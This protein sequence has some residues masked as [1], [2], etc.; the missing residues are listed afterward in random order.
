MS[1]LLCEFTHPCI[2]YGPIGY[3]RLATLLFD[4]PIHIVLND[5]IDQIEQ[6]DE[7][8][9]LFPPKDLLKQGVTI[10]K[11][12]QR[13]RAVIRSKTGRVDS[14]GP[15]YMDGV[16]INQRNSETNHC[17]PVLTIARLPIINPDDLSSDLVQE[18]A[19]DKDSIIKL[20]RF[21][22]FVHSNYVGQPMSFIENDLETRIHDYHLAAQKWGIRTIESSFSISA[23]DNVLAGVCSALTAGIFGMPISQAASIGLAATV[24][25]TTLKIGLARRT[26]NLHQSQKEIS[27]FAALQSEMRDKN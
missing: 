4:I 23:A 6:F 17:H 8:E 25:V 15:L 22:A 9:R 10:E 7:L 2:V 27:Y 11:D 21:K 18:I 16:V 3:H 1:R 14:F 24:G 5:Q 26:F 12:L 20:R 19:S 13:K